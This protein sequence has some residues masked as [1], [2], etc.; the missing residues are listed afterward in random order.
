MGKN[1]WGNTYVLKSYK[2]ITVDQN[3]GT[4]LHIDFDTMPCEQ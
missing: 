3:G 4:Q 2:W 1:R